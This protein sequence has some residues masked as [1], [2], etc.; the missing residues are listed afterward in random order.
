VIA[1]PWR[2]TQKPLGGSQGRWEFGHLNIGFPLGKIGGDF[3]F[4]ERQK[5]LRIG[6]ESYRIAAAI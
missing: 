2:A 3:T 1:A 6:E 4:M 5:R